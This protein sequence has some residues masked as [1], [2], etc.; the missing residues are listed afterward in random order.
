MANSSIPAGAFPSLEDAYAGAWSTF[1]DHVADMQDSN[2]SRNSGMSWKAILQETEAMW[3]VEQDESLYIQ[4]ICPT[5]GE[6]TLV[7]HRDS[8]ASSASRIRRPRSRSRQHVTDEG[9]AEIAACA[10][11]FLHVGPHS[12][13]NDTPEHILA[14]CISE[15][16][17]VA[18]AWSAV[19]ERYGLAMALTSSKQDFRT[20]STHDWLSG[21]RDGTEK[22]GR[23]SSAI[24]QCNGAL[25]IRYRSASA[26]DDAMFTVKPTWLSEEPGRPRPC[27]GAFD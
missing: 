8:G 22:Y 20:A 1:V 6:S 26:R 5:N 23:I 17:G 4:Y 10:V 21:S 13:V 18:F 2:V 24:N 12:Q 7:A 11:T 19:V 3:H 27:F 25:E 16:E 9:R 14:V 15:A